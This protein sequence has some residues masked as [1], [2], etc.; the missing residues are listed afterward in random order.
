[1]TGIQRR[2]LLADDDE[3]DLILVN[4]AFQRAK[5]RVAIYQVSDG[6]EAIQ[7]LKGEGIYADR[8]RYPLPDLMLMDIKMPR[9]SGFDVLSWLRAQ[10]GLRRLPVVIF[11]SSRQPE[12]INRAYELGANTYLVKLVDFSALVELIQR[13]NDYWI[14]LAE[15]PDCNVGP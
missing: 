13:L 1:M 3:N 5:T 12:D 6:E 11:S 7:Y 4:R 2:V 9:K 14:G 10:P 15:R 8:T